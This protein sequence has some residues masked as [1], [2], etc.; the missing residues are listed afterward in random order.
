MKRLRP[1]QSAQSHFK[2]IWERYGSDIP[3][4]PQNKDAV[5]DAVFESLRTQDKYLF[6]P[7]IGE[8]L[9]NLGFK[10]SVT[11]D[12]ET[13]NRADAFIVH[14][15]YSVPIEIKSPTEV[16]NINVKS[17]QQALENKIVLLSR[18]FYP[19]THDTTSLAIGYFYPEERSGIHELIRD[20]H[21]TYGFQI[22][23]IGVRDLLLRLW[24]K[25][26]E[27]KVLNHESILFLHG[28]YT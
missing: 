3:C 24:E 20:I 7:L 12:G 2:T 14:D 22:G 21:A 28:K 27:Q 19:T 1:I 8:I 9:N 13:N 11:R 18:K 15:Q 4:I 25:D 17:I 16:L 5:L 26:F 10:S 6:Y 23:I